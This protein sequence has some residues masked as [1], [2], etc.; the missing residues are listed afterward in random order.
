MLGLIHAEEENPDRKINA[1]DETEI[2]AVPFNEAMQFLKSKVP[3]S[4]AEWNQAWKEIGPKV[5]F[6]AF[7]VAQLGSAEVVDKAKQILLK[8]FEKGGGTYSDTWEELKKKVNVNALD[9]KPGYWEN[10]FRTNTQSAY[11]A[12][13][14]QQYEN[15]NVAAYQLMV[16]EDGRTSKICRH[17]LTASGY[18]MIISVDHPFWKKYGFPPYHFQCRTSIRAIWP[19]QVGKLGNMVE[20][21]TMKS[22]SKF[23][24]Q[25]GFGGNPLDR[26][27]WWEMTDSMKRLAEKFGVME[28]IKETE[29]SIFKSELQEIENLIPSLSNE[30]VEAKNIKE[31]NEYAK[32]VL[33]I[34]HA[35][36]KG[37]SLEAANEWNKGLYE[38]FQKFPELKKRFGF[39]G[40]CQARNKLIKEKYIKLFITDNRPLYEQ[41]VKAQFPNANADKLRKIVDN[42]LDFYS[43]KHWEDFAKKHGISDFTIAIA[44]SWTPTGGWAEEF[45]GITVNKNWVNN[46]EMFI[47]KK[48][49]IVKNKYFP[50]GCESL[51]ASLD[52]EIAHQLDAMLDIRKDSVIL[53]LWNRLSNDE[54]TNG[55]SEYAWNNS[56][57]EPIGEFI[58]EAWSEYCNNPYPRPIAKTVGDRI[59]ELY[60]TWK[61]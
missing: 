61:K 45:A 20:N 24:V 37:V 46:Y 19:S 8:S 15:S 23:K 43:K 60:T 41:W 28:I 47:A 2:P 29:V 11:I 27:S 14:L 39:V 32:K 9:I 22:L 54:I 52:H 30:F 51:R 18:G 3:M 16:I 10:V 35:D 4:K 59:M 48:T 42:S 1:A 40:E 34:P 13:K 26:G 44:E 57:N 38:N 31:A 55:L 33:G 49:I 21:P 6:R 36:Y 25:E 50:I 12:G 17:L 7:T 53:N 5:R 56:N 58:A